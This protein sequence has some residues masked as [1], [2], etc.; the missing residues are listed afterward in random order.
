[1]AAR[2]TGRAAF[3]ART[4]LSITRRTLLTVSVVAIVML[5]ALVAS[6]VLGRSLFGTPITDDVVLAEGILVVTVMLPLAALQAKDGHIRV[7]LIGREGSRY[8]RVVDRFGFLIGALFFGALGYAAMK[9]TITLYQT[10]EF[11]QGVLQVPIWPSK[12][13]FALGAL[14]LAVEFT[15]SVLRGPSG[16][17]ENDTEGSG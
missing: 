7:E 10:G 3:V 4:T 14:T 12:A 5:A 1:M 13:L 16:M 6:S 17:H 2:M 8:T 15:V 9:D 11:Y